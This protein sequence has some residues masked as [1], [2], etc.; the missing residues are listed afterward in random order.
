MRDMRII[1]IDI[2]IDIKK[3]G[4]IYRYSRPY[5]HPINSYYLINDY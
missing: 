5:T 1:V 4:C 2:I 3:K